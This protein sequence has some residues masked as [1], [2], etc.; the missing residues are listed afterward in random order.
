ME[1][2]H[3]VELELTYFEKEA[4]MP[5]FDGAQTNKF[6]IIFLFLSI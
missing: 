2:N 6:S 4:S 5:L 1:G 3:H